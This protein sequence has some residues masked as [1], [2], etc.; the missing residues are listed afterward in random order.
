MLEELAQIARARPEQLK[1]KRQE[2][3]K[4]VGYAGRFVP[5]ELI[6][7]SGAIPYLMC[8][9][10]DPEP[11]DATMPYIIRFMSP[12]YRTQIGYHL[13]GI[14]LVMPMLDLIVLQASDVQE[15]R[16]ADI[17]D[18]LKLP[19]HRLGVP[20][21]WEKTIALGYY[22]RHLTWLKQKLE[23]LTGNPI[24]DEK[25]KESIELM[26]NV[27]TTLRKI[28]LLRREPQPRIGG[29]DFIR[30]NHYSFYCDLE[31]L[32]DKLNE[33]YEQLLN[34]QSPFP[35]RAPRIL[36]IGHVVAIGDY[37]IPKLVEDS[38]GVIVAELLEEGMRHC[39]WNVD[40]S[41][42]LMSNLAKTY[43]LE[44]YPSSFFQPSWIKRAEIIKGMVRDLSIDGVILYLLSFEEIHDMEAPIIAK[45][46]GEMG[47]PFLRLESSYEYSREARGTLVTRIESFI[48][49]AKQKRGR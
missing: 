8:R 29:H 1:K 21:D 44:R 24:S 13:L 28:D 38:G 26:N 19:A 39:S 37:I 20:A 23:A 31:V 41:G 16:I 10:G 9:G 40:T 22:Q 17:F 43:Y 42:D 6:H 3:A 7:A 46:V 35:A 45:A 48:E 47:I 15:S 4:L 49:S 12:Y 14:D 30:L 34:A 36:L 27:R 25:L 33:L 32:P 2:G 11:V 18:Y 5:E